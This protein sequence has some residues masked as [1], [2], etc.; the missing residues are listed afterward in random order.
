M[1]NLIEFLTKND[2][3]QLATIK[4]NKPVMRPFKFSFERDGKFYFSTSNTKEVFNQL[5]TVKAAAFAV[6]AEDLSW[7][8]ISGEVEIVTDLKIK[9]EIIKVNPMAQKVIKSAD[10]PYFE[11]FCIHNGVAS[12]HDRLGAVLEE[13]TI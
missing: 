8:R 5:K 1:K 2:F 9:E 4:D 13:Y 3:G 6:L 11:V 7:A 10:N 12:L